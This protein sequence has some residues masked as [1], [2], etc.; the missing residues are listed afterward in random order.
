MITVI[1]QLVEATLHHAPKKGK[2]KGQR[3]LDYI[4][5]IIF[6]ATMAHMV[7]SLYKKIGP[8][9]VHVLSCS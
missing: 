6:M 5:M 2:V 8:I 3:H 4:S 1:A 7:S 9:G